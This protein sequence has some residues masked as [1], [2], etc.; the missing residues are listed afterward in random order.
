VAREAGISVDA[1]RL[2]QPQADS[3]AVQTV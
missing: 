3:P 1:L 2:Y